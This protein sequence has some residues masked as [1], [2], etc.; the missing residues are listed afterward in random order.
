MWTAS[1]LT[2]ALPEGATLIAIKYQIVSFTLSSFVLNRLRSLD[3]MCAVRVVIQV[4]CEVKAFAL[5]LSVHGTM[6]L[7]CQCMYDEASV[8][9]SFL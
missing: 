4:P 9:F 7:V 1:C 2:F 3:L 5:A 6:C 8:W